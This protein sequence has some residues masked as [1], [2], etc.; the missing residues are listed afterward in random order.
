[1]AIDRI[2]SLIGL[3]AV[4]IAFAWLQPCLRAAD[5]LSISWTN[6][7]LRVSGP[8]LP[9]ATLEILYLE[10]FCRSGS[11]RRDWRQTTLPHRT[12]LLAASTDGKRLE[13]LTR[14]EPD[15]EVLHEVRASD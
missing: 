12:S 9:G 1:M 7:L 4:V 3:L 11:T 14:V 6:N 10:A 5:G 8:N 15:V 13:L 2:R